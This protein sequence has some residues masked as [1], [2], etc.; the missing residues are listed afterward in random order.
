VSKRQRL[1]FKAGCWAAFVTAAVHLMGHLAGPQSPAN[2]TER[3]LIALFESYRFLLPGGSRRT[4]A[5]FMAG[6]SLMYSVFLAM[7]GG[8]NLLVV[9]RCADDAPLMA[10]LTRLDVACGVT[11]I[12]VSLRHF[13]IVPT[14]FVV[15]VTVCFAAALFGPRTGEVT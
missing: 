12:A 6:F 14:L 5:E 8:L 4:L 9:R 10:M 3:Q 7:L 15:A 1:W 13:F 11:A 2:E